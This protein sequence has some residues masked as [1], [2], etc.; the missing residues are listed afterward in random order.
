MSDRTDAAPNADIPERLC[1][2][3][4]FRRNALQ[5]TSGSIRPPTSRLSCDGALEQA[6]GADPIRPLQLRGVVLS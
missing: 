3:F 1:G 6:E 4:D 2:D 5:L